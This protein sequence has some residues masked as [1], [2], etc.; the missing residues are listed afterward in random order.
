[1]KRKERKGIKGGYVTGIGERREKRAD[2]KGEEKVER[3]ANKLEGENGNERD[4]WESEGE[5]KREEKLVWEKGVKERIGQ[6]C[7]EGRHVI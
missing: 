7:N 1:M 5:R 6:T 2:E 4:A 3:G